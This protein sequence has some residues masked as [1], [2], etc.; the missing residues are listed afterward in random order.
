M[1]KQIF[2]ALSIII[3]LTAVSLN[4]SSVK[5]S[6]C[7]N[8][9]QAGDELSWEVLDY[10]ETTNLVEPGT[11][12]TTDYLP[13]A[14]YVLN[15][16]ENI[17]F[18]VQ[19][20]STCGGSIEI[21]NLTLDSIDRH[22]IGLNLMLITGPAWPPYSNYSFDPAFL[23]P[24]NWATQIAIANNATN[25]RAGA[26]II[27]QTAYGVFLGENRS[28]VSFNFTWGSQIT[29]TIYD[30][31]TGLLL[32]AYIKFELWWLEISITTPTGIPSFEGILSI[33][34]LVG[35]ITIIYNKRKFRAFSEFSPKN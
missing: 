2:L 35:L 31:E 11:W 5:A 26:S 15:V 1:R 4:L 22:D 13:V 23:C 21:G 19:N 8:P 27:I 16:G 17:E 12:T 30:N 34:L 29:N 24:T 28:V 33:L 25:E 32:Y 20:P 14:D 7:F 6:S 10:N 9:V 3:L 18:R